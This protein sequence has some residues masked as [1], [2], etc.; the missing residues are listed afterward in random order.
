MKPGIYQ[1]LLGSFAAFGS[2]LFGYDL[3]VIAEVVAADDFKR[4]FL[5]SNS[6]SRSGTVVSL[7]T[8]GCFFGALGAGYT[9][10]LGRRGTILL[11]SLIFIVGGVI[12]TAGVAIE[13]LYIGRL[14][15]GFGIGFLVMIIPVYQSEIAHRRIR[16]RI[17]TLQ[18]LFS[19][20]GQV[21]AT[22]ASFGAYSTW[23][24][25]DSRS[26]RVP[27]AIQLIPA[28]FLSAFIFMLPESPRWLCDHD[29]YEEGLNTLARLHAHGDTNDDYVQEEFLL[30][31]AQITEEH[32]EKKKTYFDLI[33]TRA[34]L[35]RTVLVMMIQ[36]G[37]Q[38]TG[39]SAIQYFS[40][41]IFAQLG[42][43]TD[44]TLLFVAVNACIGLCGT[45][46]CIYTIDRIGRR[47]L[48]IYGSY[49]MAVT[50]LVNAIL[51]KKFPASTPNAGAHWGFI[52]MT[53]V[54]NFFFFISSGP[55]SWA[56]PPELWGTAY[57]TKGVSLGAMTSFAF[58]TMIGQVT[59]V[60][61]PAIGWRFYIVFI[62]CNVTNGLFFWAFLPE[63]KGLNLEDMDDLFEN[64][65]IFVPRSNWRP[66]Q[67]EFIEV[68]Q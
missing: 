61:I 38:M 55:L 31:K 24:K 27:L 39:V 32:A 63:T 41:E 43:S 68:K 67:E 14:V 49:I 47:P 65:A 15:S 34:N 12:Q 58:N 22:W 21:A 36:C 13:M 16:G 64:S 56:I 54:F 52:V 23:N 50:F 2:F 30:I 11:A 20:I 57:R 66:K 29:R 51:I 60:A 46:L 45:A 19:A 18:Q 1:F 42:I 7:F 9:D 59:P 26:W 17:T 33:R 28:I 3:G 4:R 25:V 5:Q 48:E 6:G 10:R 53:W 62:V 35:R 44:S 40:P 8:G 37:C